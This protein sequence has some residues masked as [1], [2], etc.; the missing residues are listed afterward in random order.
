MSK[1]KKFVAFAAAT[2]MVASMAMNVGAVSVS[3]SP[4][5]SPYGYFKGMLTIST[6]STGSSKMINSDTILLGDD[7][8]PEIGADLVLKQPSTGEIL[9]AD[10]RTNYNAQYVNC[11][12]ISANEEVAKS[13][14]TAN[15]IHRVGNG[16]GAN[17]VC[18][19]TLT[20]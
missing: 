12:A 18:N 7:N 15:S 13:I 2:A 17:W 14:V 19:L 9:F 1:F 8:A 3:S 16:N 11:Y 6:S 5:Y 10:S 4:T 20:G